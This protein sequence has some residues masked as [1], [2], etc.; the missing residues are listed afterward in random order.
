[1]GG[2]DG[3]QKCPSMFFILCGNIENVFNCANYCSLELLYRFAEVYDLGGG[4]PK[5]ISLIGNSF[6]TR[7]RIIVT[8]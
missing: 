8:F 4:Y 2:T 3:D 6:K 7:E 5:I 1:M